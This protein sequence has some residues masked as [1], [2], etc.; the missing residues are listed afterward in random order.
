MR[1]IKD[2]MIIMKSLSGANAFMD[3]KRR[4]RNTARVVSTTDLASHLAIRNLVNC[5]LDLPEECN[6]QHV[7]GQDMEITEQVADEITADVADVTRTVEAETSDLEK[8]GDLVITD[9]SVAQPSEDQDTTTLCPYVSLM[10]N[11]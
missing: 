7:A 10:L 5:L 3:Y 6:V 9:A 4:M 11:C 1:N 2:F 8:V